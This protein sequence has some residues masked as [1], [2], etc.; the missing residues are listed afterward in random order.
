MLEHENGRP[1]H[2]PATPSNCSIQA[3]PD[4][5]YD[6]PLI[7]YPGLWTHLATIPTFEELCRRRGEIRLRGG[8]LIPVVIP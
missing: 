2:G 7:E 1:H 3:A 6:T 5:Y 4:N 8:R